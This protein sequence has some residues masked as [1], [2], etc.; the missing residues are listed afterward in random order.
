[1]ET[2]RRTFLKAGAISSLAGFAAGAAEAAAAD[3]GASV[4]GVLE[5]PATPPTTRKGDM[6][7]RMLGRTGAQVSLIGL[8]GFHIG[9][10]KE[11]ADSI[12]LIR[13]AIDRGITF[14]D[15]CW[16]YND[17]QSEIRE[18]K[19]LRDGYRDKVFLMTKIDG[20]TRKSA[21]AQLDESLERLQ[22]DHLDLLQ[23][24]E[25]IQVDAPDRIF[26]EDGAVHALLEAKK[27][28]KIRFI[29]FTGHK[30]PMVHLRMLEV[31]KEHGFAFDTVQMPINVLDANFR[32]FQKQVL[33]VVV[34]EGIGA[35]A[36]KTF[37]GHFIVD[38]MMKTKLAAPIE[39][40]HYAMTLPVSVVITGIDRPEILDQAFQAA[41]T[42]NPLTPEQMAALRQRT[43]ALAA[44]GKFEKFK[45]TMQFDS[46]A[47]HPEWLG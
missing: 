3:A 9:Q 47:K 1:M 24:H 45:T 15:N 31:A 18:G 5:M 12:R 20:R 26:A 44:S 37:G 32:S 36:M 8:G 17:G 42:F 35:L 6:L 23:F 43:Q 39:M 21:S 27:A 25:V 13:S 19:A 14:L 33:P 38:E 29:G 16:D 28:G 34:R 4:P 46:T 10:Q 2:N 22:T 30:D 40:L 7:Y 41:K 11:E